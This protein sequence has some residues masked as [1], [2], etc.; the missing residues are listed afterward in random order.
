MIFRQEIPQRVVFNF[1]EYRLA[2]L[3]KYARNGPPLAAFYACVEFNE[4]KTQF[5]GQRCAHT[6]LAGP[7]E[8]RKDVDLRCCHKSAAPVSLFVAFLEVD[9]TTEGM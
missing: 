7:H 1:P 3:L 5:P 4:G 8:S 2:R 6:T 9:F